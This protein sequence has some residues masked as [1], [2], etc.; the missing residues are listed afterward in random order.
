M[1]NRDFFVVNPFQVFGAIQ[2]GPKFIKDCPDIRISQIVGDDDMEVVSVW[3]LTD[4]II[5]GPL[6]KQSGPV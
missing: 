4:L 6:C 1:A 5:Q 2:N 3:E